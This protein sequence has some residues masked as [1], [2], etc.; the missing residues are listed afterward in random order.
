MYIHEFILVQ[1]YSGTRTLMS[2]GLEA[3]AFKFRLLYTNFKTSEGKQLIS[4][5]EILLNDYFTVVWAG[6]EMFFKIFKLTM[7]H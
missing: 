6:E 5:K 3:G 4:T 2:F 1:I 7:T